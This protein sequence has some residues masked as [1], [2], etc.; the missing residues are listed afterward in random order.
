MRHNSESQTSLGS[1]LF[2][3]SSLVLSNARRSIVVALSTEGETAAA[4]LASG[5]GLLVVETRRGRDS[6][7]LPPGSETRRASGAGCRFCAE[8]VRESAARASDAKLS[9]L[10][11]ILTWEKRRKFNCRELMK[12]GTAR[13]GA[14]LR[15]LR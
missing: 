15:A 14:K 5:E 3:R 10:K 4:A 8:A 6:A 9:S 11:P 2:T 12:G 13:L 1:P 7:S